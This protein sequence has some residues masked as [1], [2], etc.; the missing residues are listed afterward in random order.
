MR[1]H[2]GAVVALTG[3]LALAGCGAGGGTPDPKAKTPDKA[4]LTWTFDHI[5]E[6]SGRITDLAALA[7]DDIWAV[8]AGNAASAPARLLHYD[9]GRWRS[10]PLPE[11]LARTQYPP[12]LEQ[13]GEDTVWLRTEA[14]ETNPTGNAWL[15]WDGTRWS[16]VANP[17]TGLVGDIEATGPEDIWAVGADRRSVRHWDGTR[18]SSHRVP[19]TVE[20]LAVAGPDDVW[21]AGYRTTGPGTEAVHGEPYDQP[22]TAHWD[23]AAF[24]SV[25][26]PQY[27]FPDPVPP[28]PGAGLQ[29]LFVRGDG[30]V[31]AFG[32][33]SYNHGEVEN[34]PGDESVRLRWDGTRWRDLPPEQGGCADRPPVLDEG[35][36]LV[37]D[38][39]WYVT[40]AGTC[41]KI[42]RER[43]PG[44]TGARAGSK[45]SLWL[46]SVLRVPGTDT[47]IGAGHVQV[48]QSGAPFSAPVVVRLEGKA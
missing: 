48:N 47:V 14:V 3:L 15:T 42:K 27:R 2:A 28:E 38:G 8:A 5:A 36:G 41:V 6:G 26:T 20:D 35:K 19:H 33:H 10:D 45:Q 18:W 39:N 44:S 9:G 30:E 29:M 40:D 25:E 46:E 11:A 13:L 7:P 17:P 37:L 4:P 1:R 43:L 22:A 16:P 12:R 21:T 31:R 23:G 34:E 24:T 32:T